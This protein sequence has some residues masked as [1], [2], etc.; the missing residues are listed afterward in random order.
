MLRIVFSSHGWKRFTQ[1]SSEFN[2]CLEEAEKRVFDAVLQGNHSSTVKSR[3]NKVYYRYY[4]D[5]I[6][7]FVYGFENKRTDVFR[8]ESVILKRGRE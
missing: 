1:R 8:V 2:L 4:D 3:V 7:F 5:N 6:C